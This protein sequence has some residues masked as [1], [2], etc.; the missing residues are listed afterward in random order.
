M[1]D[2]NSPSAT[3]NDAPSSEQGA[4]EMT[5]VQERIEE[6]QAAV[7]EVPDDEAM[8]ALYETVGL[9]EMEL[10]DAQAAY[11]SGMARRALVYG[12]SKIAEEGGVTPKMLHGWARAYADGIPDLSSVPEKELPRE[13][14]R[15]E[16]ELHRIEEDR[17][18]QELV[19]RQQARVL[20]AMKGWKK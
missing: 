4:D 10:S 7:A 14:K 9:A 20:E 12:W 18:R 17:A 5:R 6:W 19:E 11:R 15:V 2:N 8:Q 1:Q 13:A 3:G 16:R